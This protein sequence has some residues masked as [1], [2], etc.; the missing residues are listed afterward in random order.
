MTIFNW[1]P[2]VGRKLLKNLIPTCF[3]TIA[4]VRDK[5]G[6]PSLLKLEFKW[7]KE[8]RPT[9]G[10]SCWDKVGTV[11]KVCPDYHLILG[12]MAKHGIWSTA[13]ARAS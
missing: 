2:N 1:C 6:D 8:S 11:I 7:G 12:P 13:A 4:S 5:L 9:P 3:S 10:L